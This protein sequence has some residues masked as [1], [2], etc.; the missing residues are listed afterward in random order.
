MGKVAF[1]FPGQGA[2]YVGMGK[3]LWEAFPYVREMFQEASE[4]LGF[5]LAKLCFEG[6]KEELV[7]T[8]NTQPAV[9][10]VS[11]ACAEVMRRELGVEPHLV[12]GHS[13]GEYTA[14]WFSGA[15]PFRE[16]VRLVRV[17]G[18]LMEAACPH[19]TGGMA[20]VLGL[21]RER[22]E[23]LCRE[24]REGG[25]VLVPANFNCPGQVV[26]SG[27]RRSL[28]KAVSLAKAYGAKRAVVLEVS[29]PFHS[30]LMEPAAEGLKGVLEGLAF[31]ELR[32]PVVSNV[33]AKPNRS[34]SRAKELL[35]LQVKSPVLWEDS[36][37]EMVALGVDTFV[38]LGPGKVLSGL[39]KR[40]VSEARTLNLEGIEDLDPLRE[41]FRS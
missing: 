7:K 33:E 20:A 23:D 32:V 8:E 31:G 29:G 13:L 36:V 3:G 27:H 18:E 34:P 2:Q 11:A 16:A 1:V 28:E 10:A 38:E 41:A 15:L 19:G 6:P 12:A 24:S 4:A 22:V 39:I 21:A 5:D 17:R 40:T 26:I 35:I 30:P 9:L 25:E 14:L 37:R